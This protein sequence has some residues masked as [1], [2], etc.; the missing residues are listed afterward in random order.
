VTLRDI[1][2]SIYRRTNKN[3]SVPNAETQARIIG[4]INDRHRDVLTDFPQLRDETFTFPTVDSQQQYA[5]PEHGIASISRIVDRS[6]RIRLVQ[7]SDDWLDTVDPNPESGTSIVWVPQSYT[8]VHTQPSAACEVFI[9]STSASDVNRAY[10]EGYDSGGYRR[11]AEVTMTGVTAVSL[12]TTITTWIQIDKVYLSEEAVG[13]VTLHSVSGAGTQLSKIAI[14]DTYAK[15]ISF[16]LWPTP[17]AVVTLS[18]RI[19]RAIGEMSKP[20]DEPLLPIDFHQMLAVGARLDE[21]EHTDDSRRGLAET[22]WDRWHKKLTTHLVATPD[23]RIDLNT[24][25]AHGVGMSRLGSNY[26]AGT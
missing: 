18:A 25:L 17:S 20:T 19:R 13:T 7:K 6:N 1:A 15:F 14:G 3:A 23:T 2:R 11:T 4:F 9:K 24:D 21:Y 5:L 26:P 10:V 22:E 8:Q 12:D 16:L